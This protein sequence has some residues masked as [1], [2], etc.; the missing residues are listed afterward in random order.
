MCGEGRGQ[1]EVSRIFRGQ[2]NYC[3]CASWERAPASGRDK[4]VGLGDAL[5]S[6]VSKVKLLA[7]AQP[8]RAGTEV[9]SQPRDFS[10]ARGRL[11]ADL[12][13][14]R[15]KSD[16]VNTVGLTSQQ[17][18]RGLRAAPSPP[19]HGNVPHNKLVLDLGLRKKEGGGGTMEKYLKQNAATQAGLQGNFGFFQNPLVL[20]D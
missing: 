4:P 11:Q 13:L 15:R 6:K 16:P 14:P 20:I 5:P 19:P 2:P 8:T 17:S 10:R 3:S 9:P 1:E 7:G 18:C 12:L